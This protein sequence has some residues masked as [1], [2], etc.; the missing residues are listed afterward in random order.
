MPLLDDKVC[1]ITGGCGSVGLAAA[2][3]FLAEGARVMLVD[4]DTDRL[5]AARA[6]L[7]ADR[8]ETF[9]GDVADPTAVRGSIEATTARWRIMTR[10]PST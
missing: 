3:R 5:A 7:D 9:A 8:V 6:G 10:R 2:R 1:V 4:R